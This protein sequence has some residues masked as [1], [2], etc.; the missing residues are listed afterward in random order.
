MASQTNCTQPNYAILRR[1]KD[2]RKRSTSSSAP[3]LPQLDFPTEVKRSVGTSTHS[4]LTSGCIV[5]AFCRVLSA[6]RSLRFGREIEYR[7]GSIA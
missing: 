7:R 6:A 3:L 2:G 5:Y 1:L 4:P